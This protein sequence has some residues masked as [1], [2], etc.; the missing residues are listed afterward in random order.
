[1]KAWTDT[2]KDTPGSQRK[3]RALGYIIDS[4]EEL[5][6]LGIK[7]Q[8]I[9]RVDTVHKFPPVCTKFAASNNKGWRNSGG[10]SV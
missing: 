1:M 10:T 5:V 4:I 3:K 9:C 2:D 8:S 7:K 6:D